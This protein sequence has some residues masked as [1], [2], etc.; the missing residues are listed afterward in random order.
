[1][2]VDNKK[3]SKTKGE[4]IS[5][6]VTVIETPPIKILSVRFYKTAPYGKYVST[7]VLNDNLDKELSRKLN[8]PKKKSFQEKF[9]EL[10]TNLD[11]YSE[12]RLVLY[13]QPKLVPALG[14][15]KPEVFEC[16]LGGKVVD[17]FN[18]V[19]ENINKE[20]SVKDIIQ[21][22]MFVDIHAVTKGKGTQGPVKRFG[23]GLT[24][25]KS[26]K[27]RRTPGSLGGWIAQGHIMYRVAYAGQTGYHKRTD[28]NKLVLKIGDSPEEI[29]V[30]G[31]FKHYGEVKNHFIMV[32]GSI[33]GLAKRVVRVIPA[34]RLP[35]KERV[36]EA[37]SI[38][39][40]S[41]SSVQG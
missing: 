19:K 5:V 32:K 37:P 30:K 34:V 21:E 7:E 14:K 38:V 31:G 8:L 29:N 25:H 2:I 18:W 20:I 33:P 4:Q 13:T 28:F 17:Q 9:S 15:K 6:P 12:I 41:L 35:Q 16:A 24:S 23:I 11:S 22:G 10:E 39:Y 26:E 27:S 1:V 3:S 36:I 40:T